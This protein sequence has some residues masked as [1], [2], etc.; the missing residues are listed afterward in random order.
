MPVR[1]AMSTCR[2]DPMRDKEFERELQDLQAELRLAI[3]AKA[4]NLD[5]SLEAIAQRRARVLLER[6]FEF[7]AWTYFPHHIWGEPSPFQRDFCRRLPQLLDAA[8]GCREW[9]VAPRGEN[10]STLLTKIG[11]CFVVVR[12]LLQDPEFRADLGL[13]LDPAPPKIDYLLLFSA[14]TTLAEKM[15]AVVQVELESNPQLR[16]DFPKIMGPGP[17]WR[18][19]AITT[20]NH[21]RIEPKGADQ[22][23]RGSF[24][25]ASRPQAAFGDDWLKDMEARSPR[26]TSK[27]WDYFNQTVA[28]LG[29]PGAGLKSI[30]AATNIST[31]DMVSRARK[32]PDDVV[33]SYKALIRLPIR[34]HLWAQAEERMHNEDRAAI[35]ADKAEGRVTSRERLPSYTYYMEHQAAM[36]AGGE[37]SWEARSL[38]DLMRA[39]AVNRKAFDSELQNNAQRDEDR[40]FTD[41]RFWVQR[42]PHWTFF[43]ACDPSM[44]T[45]QTSHPSG[46]IAGGWDRAAKRLHVV[47][48]DSKRRVPTKLNSDLISVQREFNCQAIAFEENNAYAYM[49]TQFIK[50]AAGEGVVLPL[51]GVTATVNLDVR[52]DSLEPAVNGVDPVIL[53]HAQLYALIDQL[54]TWPE[55]P[56]GHHYDLLSAPAPAAPDRRDQRRRAPAA[57]RPTQARQCDRRIKRIAAMTPEETQKSARGLRVSD[58]ITRTT[59]PWLAT[60]RVLAE[61]GSR[62]AQVRHGHR[63]LRRHRLRRPCHGR[64]ALDPR[65]PP[66]LPVAHRPPAATTPAANAPTRL[67]RPGWSVPAPALTAVGRTCSGLLPRRCFEVGPFTSSAGSARTA[68]CSPPGSSTPPSTATASITRSNSAYSPRVT[69]PKARSRTRWSTWLSAT[70]RAAASPTVPRSSPLAFGPYVLKTN[71]WKW[72]EKLARRHAIPWVI[73][74]YPIGT[75][76]EDQDALAEGLAKMVEDAVA[77]IPEGGAVDL[78]E[79]KSTGDPVSERVIKTSNREMSK[80]LTSQTL[81]TEQQDTGARAATQT[82]REREEDTQLTDREMIA[83]ALDQVLSLITWI[84][85]GPAAKPSKWEFFDEARPPK[86]WVEVIDKARTFLPIGHRQAYD[87]LQLEPPAKDDEPIS[88]APSISPQ[89]GSPGGAG[90]DFAAGGDPLR[91]YAATG[92][93]AADGLIETMA[94]EVR[95]LLDRVDTLEDFRDGLWQLYPEISEQRLGELTAAA[96]LTGLLQGADD[97]RDIDG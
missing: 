88:S 65:R 33:H 18:I 1:A 69:S 23:V 86:D 77:A 8:Q 27:R 87:L 13:S 72:F 11:P 28:H 16:L 26:V 54:T 32:S 58:I 35:E 84:N 39:R 20:R 49:R 41:I 7:F 25:G 62:P 79:T 97:V 9:W 12:H 34:M 50:S 36:D 73:G 64:A 70:C 42:L 40:V 51:I 2:I 38:Y 94:E 5:T 82:H 29:P 53:F 24:F 92:A 74:R 71:G 76:E 60:L 15:L 68:S 21:V 43:A 81:A 4:T 47:H 45:G 52:I 10:K 46:I 90:A 78:L 55:P 66:Q 95:A 22:H 6:D 89:A 14:E 17:T 31:L 96:A 80:A 59:D 67:S 83:W 75:P 3:E 30:N 48:A 19:G 37:V 63:D 56:E 61:S 91:E 93:A 44:G 85:V 57:H